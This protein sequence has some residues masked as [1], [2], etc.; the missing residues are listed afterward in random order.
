MTPWDVFISHASEDKASFVQP[1]AERLQRLA[2]RV[3]YDRFT[4]V[5]GDPLSESIGE[6]LS[7]SRCGLVVISP[8][9]LKK[10]WTKY[11]LSGLINRFVED[12]MRLIPI[13]LGVSRSDVAAL[14]PSLADLVAIHGTPEDVGACAIAVL[15]VVRPQLYKNLRMVADLRTAAVRIESRSEEHT[16]ELQ[17]H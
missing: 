16:S 13:W 8:N 5:P 17:S 15:K 10:P 14:N 7:Q 2:V 12:K 3:W 4:L 9:F 11:E 1:L 6:G